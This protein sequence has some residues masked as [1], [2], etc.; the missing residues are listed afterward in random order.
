MSKISVAYLLP[1][2][3]SDMKHIANMTFNDFHVA[4]KSDPRYE[5][6]RPESVEDLDLCDIIFIPRIT[7]FHLMRDTGPYKDLMIA[8]YKEIKTG[9]LKKP[10]IFHH[11]DVQS[12]HFDGLTNYYQS[13]C[14]ILLIPAI[15]P[16][17]YP[18]NAHQIYAPYASRVFPLC[19]KYENAI[20]FPCN[21]SNAVEQI[22][23]PGTR[24]QRFFDLVNKHPGIE[25]H[26]YGAGWQRFS[27]TLPPNIIWKGIEN[28]HIPYAKYK[29]VLDIH[30]TEVL[31]R[32]MDSVND[33]DYL[34]P[35]WEDKYMTSDRVYYTLSGLAHPITDKR[36]LMKYIPSARHLDDPID[37]DSFDVGQLKR[38]RN[39]FLER[40]VFKGPLDMLHDTILEVFRSPRPKVHKTPT[41]S[42]ARFTGILARYRADPS[43]LPDGCNGLGNRDVS[44]PPCKVCPIGSLCEVSKEL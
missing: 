6:Y 34:L 23:V 18:T 24:L 8:V 1:W 5:V 32:K 9:R 43:L 29:F 42:Q 37:M 7:G 28:N 11:L 13:E 33:H 44:V 39:R 4:M 15:R 16:F 12:R 3:D 41:P 14:D 17:S 40:N 36:W 35:N 2:Y 26:V 38:D 22:G 20:S 27:K 19:E 31:D 25:F 21:V 10:Y 30:P